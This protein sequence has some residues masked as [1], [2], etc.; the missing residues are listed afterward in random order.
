MFSLFEMAHPTRRENCTFTRS[1]IMAQLSWTDLLVIRSA[2]RVNDTWRT[3]NLAAGRRPH[4]YTGRDSYYSLGIS[5]NPDLARVPSSTQ[6]RF[7]VTAAV[8]LTRTTRGT[9]AVYAPTSVRWIIQV[10]T[11][12]N[13]IAEQITTICLTSI[14]FALP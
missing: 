14:F 12:N 13:M 10:A 4:V 8:W 11:R 3:A 9:T 5:D 2:Y 7:K 6:G 1:P